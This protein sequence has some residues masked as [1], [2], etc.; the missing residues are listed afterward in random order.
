MRERLTVVTGED[1]EGV[2]RQTETVEQREHLAGGLVDPVHLGAIVGV[3]LAHARQVGHM[4][5]KFERRGI[6]TI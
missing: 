2:F 3:L 4:G 6:G 1:D 5:R